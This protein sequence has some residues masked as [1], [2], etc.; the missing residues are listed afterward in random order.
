MNSKVISV[1]FFFAALACYGDA[2]YEKTTQ[3]T[4]GQLVDMIKKFSFLSKSMRQVTAPTTETTMVHGNQKAIVSKDYTEI[5]DLD[6]ESI[7]HIDNNNKTYT[8]TTFADMRKMMQ[9]LPAKM[10]QAQQQMKDQQAKMQQ[11]KGQSPALPPDLKVDFT[12]EVKDTGLTKLIDKYNARQQIVTMKANIT[13]TTNPDTHV[14]YSFVEEI[15]TTPSLP[16]EMKAVNDFDLRFGR[17][18]MQGVDIPDLFSNM[19]A[20]RNG[21]GAAMAQMFGS[22]PGAADAFKQMQV[23]MAKI[24]G[25]KVIE[26][27]RMGGSGTGAPGQ[28]DGSTASNP[29]AS[30]Q[31]SFGGSPGGALAGAVFKAWGRKKA[32]STDQDPPPPPP[33]AATPGAPTDVT[34]MEM[35]AKTSGFSTENVSP[36]VFQIPAGYKQVQSSIDKML[37]QP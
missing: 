29:P 14:T 19:S 8:V 25:T 26:I 23:E 24:T 7:I 5:W 31:P 22:Q 28:A 32:K 4:G 3:V 1:T 36:A 27:T 16:D 20:M 11:Q 30:P 34:L 2:S 33:A 21:S 15:W 35:T 17:Q 13:D 6:K 10:A 9:E 12:T 18:M 37:S